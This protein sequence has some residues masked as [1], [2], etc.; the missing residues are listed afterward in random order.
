MEDQKHILIIQLTRIG[1]LIQTVQAC[2]QIKA[3]NPEV[4]LSLLAREK[5]ASGIIF[6][7]ET[8]F[9]HIYLFETKDFFAQGNFKGAT[10]SV[11]RFMQKV[12]HIKYD[13]SVNFSFSKSSSYLHSLINARHKMGLYRNRRSEVCINDKWSQYVYSNVLNNTDV[14]FSLVDIYRYMLGCKETYAL[15]PDEN[16]YGRDNNIVLHPFASQRKKKWGLNRW[17]ELIYKIAKDEPDYQFHIVGSPEDKAEGERLLSSPALSSIK[18]RITLHA[19]SSSI[20]DC[21]QLLMNAKLFIGHDSMVSHLASETLTPSIVVS[22]GTV[23]PHETSPYSNMVV[24]L[25]PKNQCFPC[26]VSDQ[27]DL[28]P[29]HTSINH[30]VVTTIASAVLHGHELTTDYLKTNLTPFHL[31]TVKI[32]KSSYDDTGLYFDELSENH[33]NI[34]DVFKAYY[35]II[36]LYYLRGSETS[37][38]LPDISTETASKLNHYVSGINYLFELYN[39]GVNYSNKIIE[40]AEGKDNDFKA[41]QSYIDKL[42]EIDQLCAVTKKTFPL[43]KGLIDFFYVNKANALGDNLIDISKHNVLNYYDASNLVAVMSEFIEKSI[44][45]HINA[46]NRGTEV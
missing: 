41:V 29:C 22:L 27:C 35:K 2:R 34:N 43:L 10:E 11:G 3:E 5:F 30:Q 37:T 46:N 25:S 19:G 36:W 38:Q 45:P 28:L 7:L 44:T 18:N 4:V 6:L 12:N 14:P 9:D 21:Y 39:F 40:A 24:N 20:A 13:L 33:S 23:R 31:N 1:D 42:A 32:M 26:K 8:V 17:N 15:N 16:Y